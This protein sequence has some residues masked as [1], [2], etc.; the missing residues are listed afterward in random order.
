MRK[1]LWIW[2]AAMLLAFMVAGGITYQKEAGYR[3]IREVPTVD[4]VVALTFDDGPTDHGT[5]RLL[6]VLHDY[7]A[8]ATFFVLGKYAEQYPGRIAQMIYEGHEVG[9]HGY[10][11]K[12]LTK[13]NELELAEELARSEAAIAKVAP[14][15]VLFR[16]PGSAYNDKIFRELKGKG[17]TVVMWSVDPRDWA[18]KNPNGIARDVIKRVKPGSIILMHDG[19]YAPGTLAATALILADLTERGYR[20]ITVSELLQYYEMRH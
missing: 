6:K 9:S 3:G 19:D 10:S 13:L 11:H 4:K 17:Y 8:K 20:F 12:W 7:N 14:K 2:G 15:P 18:R 1:G 16:P 5:L